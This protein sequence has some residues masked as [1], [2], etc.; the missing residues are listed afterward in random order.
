ML[1]QLINTET[2]KYQSVKTVDSSR[3]FTYVLF[4]NVYL[5][6][7]YVHADINWSST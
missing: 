1:K 5:I 2:P 6:P 7:N 4:A 3:Q